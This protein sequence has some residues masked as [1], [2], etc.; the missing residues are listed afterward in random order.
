MAD[1]CI[2]CMI[3]AKQLNII[4]STDRHVVIA[5]INPLAKGH[6]LVIPR[7]HAQYFH[8]LED[9]DILPILPL[10]KMIVKKCGIIKYNILQNNGHIQSVP[11]VHFHIIPYVN[12]SECLRITWKVAKVDSDYVQKIIE[13]S[14]SKLNA[15]N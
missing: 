1:E 12:D 2:F 9:Q 10:I 4:Y 3:C 6:L 14:V 7:K 8:E 13:D 5:D 15:E 11:H